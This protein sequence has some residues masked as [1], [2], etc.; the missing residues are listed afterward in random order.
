MTNGM[1]FVN[2]SSTWII[3]E[4]LKIRIQYILVIWSK[5]W[6]WYLMRGVKDDLNKASSRKIKHMNHAFTY[7]LILQDSLHLISLTQFLSSYNTILYPKSNVHPQCLGYIVYKKITHAVQIQ[8]VLPVSYP[9]FQT[10]IQKNP[11]I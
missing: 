3:Y 11:P 9:K 5:S 6:I 7:L 8:N 10:Q 2:F 1:A 4:L